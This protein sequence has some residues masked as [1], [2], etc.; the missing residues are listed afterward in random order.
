MAPAVGSREDVVAI[1]VVV[2]AIKIVND[3]NSNY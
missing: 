1:I 2:A 3:I